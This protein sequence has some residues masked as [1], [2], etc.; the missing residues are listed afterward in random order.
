MELP[1]SAAGIPVPGIDPTS[2][3]LGR[4]DNIDGV[5]TWLGMAAPARAGLVAAMG[6]GT[7]L[8]R[9]M[10]FI[11]LADW[12]SLLQDVRVQ[13][14]EGGEP[15]RPTAIEMGH[16]RMARRI[17]RLRLGLQPVDVGIPQVATQIDIDASQRRSGG[18]QQLA[19]LATS[20]GQVVDDKAGLEAE[21]IYIGREKKRE[22]DR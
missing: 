13:V 21:C 14:G 11:N 18:W 2:D 9:D 12:G 20:D 6:G 17:A 4:I 22:G 15:R 10:V 7:P 16:F 19:L 3:E 8:L 5:A 1:Q